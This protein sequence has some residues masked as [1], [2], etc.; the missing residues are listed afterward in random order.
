MKCGFRDFGLAPSVW[1]KTE[2]LAIRI[3]RKKKFYVR[4][5]FMQYRGFYSRLEWKIL[6]G[7]LDLVGMKAVFS[8]WEEG[9]DLV[10]AA[11]GRGGEYYLRIEGKGGGRDAGVQMDGGDFDTDTVKKICG[12]EFVEGHGSTFY[13]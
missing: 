2:W 12:D 7:V 8:G 10:V 13:E 11:M 1:L 5:D 3:I 6:L 9:E 4:I